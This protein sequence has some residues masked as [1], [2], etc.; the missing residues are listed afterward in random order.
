MQFGFLGDSHSCP[1]NAL[2]L[3]CG[4]GAVLFLRCHFLYP[5]HHM[6]FFGN[7]RQNS[8]QDG[9]QNKQD[10]CGKTTLISKRRNAA[11]MANL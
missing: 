4:V 2:R 5:N 1:F 11:L 6:Y 8:C 7:N 10:Q 9:C 3:L